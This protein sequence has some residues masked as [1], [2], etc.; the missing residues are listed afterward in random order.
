MG[1][2]WQGKQY[3]AK[4]QRHM[5]NN[6]ERTGAFLEGDIK[7]K[8]PGPKGEHS[9]AGE[10]P[11]VQTGTL[12]KAV[13]HKVED[14]PGQGPV[15]K[16]GIMEATTKGRDAEALEYALPLEVGYI[17]PK[18]GQK[19]GPWPYL[20]PASDRNRS[21]LVKEMTRPMRG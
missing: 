5:R 10:I 13:A 14:R 16:V 20:R 21:R 17:H 1:V 9:S 6:L 3:M 18:S 7:K 12:K 15:C 4:L 11:H 8:F 19:V 2:K